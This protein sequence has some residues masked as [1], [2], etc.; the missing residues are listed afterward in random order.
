MKEKGFVIAVLTLT[1]LIVYLF[2]SAPPPLPEKPDS[3]S[4][5]PIEQVF[6]IVEAENDAIRIL[7]TEE[8]VGKGKA[9]GLKFDEH[10][11]DE[12]VDAG[13]LPALFLRETA[14]SLE[15]GPVR[16]SLFL[17]SDFP[18]NPANRFQ[19]LQMDKFALISTPRRRSSSSRRI[20]NSIPPCF[21]TRPSSSRASTVITIIPM[22]RKRTGSCAM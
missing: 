7:W 14:T 11:R 6:A 4:S 17:G 8:I 12:N 13:P 3:G 21:R 19:G 20:P 10:W 5:I 18:L 22:R 9:A 15:K 2:V 1:A 16:L